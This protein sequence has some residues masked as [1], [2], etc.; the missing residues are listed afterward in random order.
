MEDSEDGLGTNESTPRLVH[1]S[2]HMNQ[3]R[4]WFRVLAPLIFAAVA[5]TF[6]LHKE[7]VWTVFP[8]LMFYLMA[9]GWIFWESRVQAEAGY[10]PSLTSFQEAIWIGL[11]SSIV[12]FF[13]FYRLTEI[14]VGITVEEVCGPY[15]GFGVPVSEWTR[16]YWAGLYTT[17]PD[18]PV[19]AYPWFHLF[20]PSRLSY[21]FF[22]AIL[23][24]ASFPFGYVLFRRLAGNR[25]AL[26][27]C[28][29]WA[30]M[31]W[32]VSLGRAG[33][34]AITSVLYILALATFGHLALVSN[35]KVFWGLTG[36]S[37]AAGLYAY[38]AFRSGPLLLVFWIFYEA[39]KRPLERKT[40]WSGL[41]IMSVVAALGSFP[42][43]WTMGRQGWLMS[44]NTNGHYLLDRILREQSLRP[45]WSQLA[46]WT[47]SF[48]RAGDLSTQAN[49]G[50]G[51]LLDDVTAILFVLGVFLSIRRIGERA[52]FYGVTGWAVLGLTA[53]LSNDPTHSSRMIGTAPFVAYLAALAASDLGRKF[54]SFRGG[55][56]AYIALAGVAAFW[57]L[58]WN[59]GRYFIERPK[60]T[61]AVQN[62]GIGP[63]MAGLAV[64]EAGKGYEYY[65]SPEY[66]GNFTVLFLGHSQTKNMH[67]LQVP[68]SIIPA[69][70]TQDKG[71]CYI[72]PRGRIGLFKVLQ[73]TYP[74]G[75]AE[76][77]K[78]PFGLP[79]LD[80]LK[81][82]A[83]T[84]P[85]AGRLGGWRGAYRTSA[86]WDVPPVLVQVDP[87]LNYDYRDD[88]PVQAYPPLRVE[89]TA[90]LRIPKTG[91]YRFLML[92][93]DQTHAE[94]RLGNDPVFQENLEVERQLATGT[95]AVTIRL[96]KEWGFTNY[97]HL[98]WKPPGSEN[99]KVI[100]PD[101]LNE[102][103]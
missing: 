25:V 95:Y 36:A 45:I 21:G 76:T 102:G 78:D 63:T 88:F 41:L 46:S 58:G 93:A 57:V 15:L 52:F 28:F 14:P 81:I 42:V 49:I 47:L 64:A 69:I 16:H 13:R 30:A 50:G 27:A 19:L 103:R 53:I 43:L 3:R 23:S 80:I 62:S 97:F 73:K 84:R 85:K 79:V 61:F 10:E 5:Q 31:Q 6:M 55:R 17:L 26:M 70:D 12:L 4:L 98:L 74:Q 56:L 101:D 2:L 18:I 67:A 29:F 91:S 44:P 40:W 9:G 72:L 11:I 90:R 75:T 20:S 59:Y 82:P 94:M 100:Q 7:H 65:L 83:G 48:V 8:A 34:A 32:H 77:M 68:R 99:F 35:R 22:Y 96:W 37:L 38:P 87:V 1:E 54:A 51:R 86:S 66:F 39:W 24:L 89:W 71:L 60:D 92:A 33:H